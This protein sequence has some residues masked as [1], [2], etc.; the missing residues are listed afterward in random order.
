[1]IWQ[2]PLNTQTIAV[3]EDYMHERG[4]WSQGAILKRLDINMCTTSA[5]AYA[6]AY[7]NANAY[8][9]ADAYADAY[10]HAY[11]NA[12]AYADAYANT[13]ANAYANAD[14]YADA[15]ADADVHVHAHANANAYA[16]AYAN[17]NAN[18][19]ANADAYAD[20]YAN[21]NANAYA[22]ADAY[23]YAYANI[24]ANAYAHAYADVG[25]LIVAPIGGKHMKNGF[26]IWS[27]LS[28][29]SVAVL[30]VGWIRRVEGDEYEA[31]NMVTPQRKGDY[32]TMFSDLAI[33]GP[34]KKW[35]FT[36]PIPGACPLNRFQIQ[37]PV[38]LNPEQWA[39]I[40]PRPEEWKE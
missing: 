14:A 20:A 22:N 4:T 9:N 34:P 13:N 33:D 38:P 35:S 3:I 7:A 11:A 8:A 32:E 40:S 15:Y 16:N 6:D 24:N 37:G 5:N 27:Q 39:K 23:A 26:Y 30:R 28:G 18:A 36:R 1:M 12:N 31:L 21:A 29:G 19:Y 25:I 2:L 17:T 10:V